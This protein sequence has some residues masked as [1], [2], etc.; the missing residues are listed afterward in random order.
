[1]V[2]GCSY[3]SF[4]AIFS[5]SIITSSVFDIAKSLKSELKDKDIDSIKNKIK[6]NLVTS[7]YDVY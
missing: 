2:I 5:S 4:G 6:F 3:P 7:R 1:M